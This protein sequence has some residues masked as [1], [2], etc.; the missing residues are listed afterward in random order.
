[1]RTGSGGDVVICPQIGVVDSSCLFAAESDA[2]SARAVVLYDPTGLRHKSRQHLDWL[3]RHQD[4]SRLAAGDGTVGQPAMKTVFLSASIPD[5][6]RDPRFFKTADVVAIAEAVHALCT[7]VLPEDRLVFGGHPAIT[8]IVQRIAVLLDRQ[9]SVAIFQS[10]FFVG[11]FPE[12]AKKFP[13]IVVTERGRD[14]GDSLRIMREAMLKARPF[15]GVFVGGMEGVIDEWR[16]LQELHSGTP[17]WPIPTTG[18]AARIL[19]DSREFDRD[20]RFDETLRTDPVYAR[21][22]R[23]LLAP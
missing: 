23:R 5:P 15:A 10:A 22:F 9:R 17:A 6:K 16:L 14:R 7:V 19:F 18:A 8:P 3:C 4:R 21:L 13:N 11:E 1:M 20:R 12:E 2:K